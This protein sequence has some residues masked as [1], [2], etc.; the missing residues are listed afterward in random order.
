MFNLARVFINH[1]TIGIQK[2]MQVHIEIIGNKTRIQFCPGNP[3]LFT[4]STTSLTVEIH[5]EHNLFKQRN[6]GAPQGPS[7]LRG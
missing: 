6:N 2:L 1:I 4:A 5:N 3:Y 7:D